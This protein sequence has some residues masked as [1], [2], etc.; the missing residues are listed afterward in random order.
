MSTVNFI[1]AVVYNVLVDKGCA[2]AKDG[3]GK[4]GQIFLSQKRG[5]RMIP[6]RETGK[7]FFLFPRRDKETNEVEYFPLP[8]IGDTI[9]VVEGEKDSFGRRSAERWVPVTSSVEEGLRVYRA[10]LVTKL[11]RGKDIISPKFG[12]DGLTLWEIMNRLKQDRNLFPRHIGLMGSRIVW[13]LKVEEGRWVE[14]E[15]PVASY[16]AM[17]YG[18]QRER[19]G[20]MKLDVPTVVGAMK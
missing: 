13:E 4:M 5:S 10:A 9:I 14:C 6:D 11:P 18:E 16:D 7:P 1:F 3:E 20:G 8:Q 15:D 2:F 12:F 19:R 17:L